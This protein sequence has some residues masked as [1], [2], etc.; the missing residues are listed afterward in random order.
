MRARKKNPSKPAKSGKKAS[1][2]VSPRRK[3]LIWCCAIFGALL[4]AALFVAWLTFSS[5]RDF[6]A[7]V[8]G[9]QHRLL[10]RRLAT[11]M[12]N[13]REL[14]EAE[15]RLS[16]QEAN[17]LLDIIRHL[18]Q[19][20]PDPKVPPPKN[21]MIRYCDDG[22]VF[23]SAPVAVAGKWCF[24]GK[25]YVSGALYF[26]KQNSNIVAEMPE[27]RFGRVDMPIPGGLDTIY[28]SWR[29]RLISSL[30]M[31]FMIPIKC[32]CS[33]RDGTLVLVYSPQELRRPLKGMLNRVGRRCSGELKLLIDQ[34][35]KSL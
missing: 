22:S 30:P 10:L 23:F 34:L 26:E 12:R 20:V 8:I 35:I 25:I 15:I 14:K 1:G 17:L 21:F 6:S 32:L 29:R 31:E 3:L 18:S 33:K 27:L 16:P 4:A 28:P 7:P 24:G 2:G 11:E 5:Y 9:E 13:N 19:F